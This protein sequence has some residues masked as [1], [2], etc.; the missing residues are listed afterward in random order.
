MIAIN[1]LTAIEF[2][3]FMNLYKKFAEK[4]YTV[5]VIDTALASNNPSR[6]RMNLLEWMQKLV[7]ATD[8]KIRD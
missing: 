4:Q 7:M 2:H 6:F 3:D 5:F 8:N 1:H